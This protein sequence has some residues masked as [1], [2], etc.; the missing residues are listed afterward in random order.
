MYQEKKRPLW[1]RM[2]LSSIGIILFLGIWEIVV[3]L[4]LVSPD[5]LVAPSQIVTTFIDKLSNP[6]PCL[7]YTS[8][9]V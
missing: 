3:Q 4:G 1:I 6:I 8:R 9:C 7:L 5:K 2:L